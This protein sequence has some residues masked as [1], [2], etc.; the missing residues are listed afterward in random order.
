MA[1]KLPES[2]YLTALVYITGQK[3]LITGKNLVIGKVTVLLENIEFQDFIQSTN[4]YP[5]LQDLP[6]WIG[7]TAI[8]LKKPLKRFSVSS[9]KKHANQQLL[10]MGRN[11]L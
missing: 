4:D 11:M 5:V 3:L 9:Q 2:E 6:G 8:V 10:I 7:L 1:E